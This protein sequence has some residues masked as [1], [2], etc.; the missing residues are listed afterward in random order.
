MKE[1]IRFIKFALFSVS[2]G[3]GLSLGYISYLLAHQGCSNRGLLGNLAS[4]KVHLMWAD[5][6]KFHSGVC[7]EIREFD[8]A[9]KTDNILAP[10]PL[11]AGF[12]EG[13]P[14]LRIDHINKVVQLGRNLVV[15]L[16]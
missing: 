16:F 7:R 3:R 15:S 11:C 14:Y 8:V 9:Q 13:I 5:N 2:A 1:Y 6:L 12:S 10:I 4:L